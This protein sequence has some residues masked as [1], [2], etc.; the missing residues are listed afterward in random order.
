MLDIDM[1]KL[2][3]ISSIASSI[4]TTSCVQKIKE[5]LTSKKYL[6]VISF[7]IS[8]V[9]GTLFSYS[10]SSLSLVNNLW[11]G[12]ISFLGSDAIYKAFEDKVFKSFSSLNINSNYID[13]DKEVSE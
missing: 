11:V 1:I 4:I 5:S 8:F 3:L 6:C 7:V 2:V 9:L 13:L 10:F 12:F